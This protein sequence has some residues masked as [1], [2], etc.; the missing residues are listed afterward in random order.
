MKSMQKHF[1]DEDLD[2][3]NA[4]MRSGDCNGCKY[5]KMCEEILKPKEEVKK[6]K[7]KIENNGDSEEKSYLEDKLKKKI[8][9]FKYGIEIKEI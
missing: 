9:E 4:C 3:I 6:K 5:E 8:F 7:L 1:I 2:F